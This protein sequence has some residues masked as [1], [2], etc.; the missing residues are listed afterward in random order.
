ME[1][2][3][4]IE[5]LLM[6]GQEV[7]PM[8]IIKLNGKTIQIGKSPLY[9]SE[10]RA[11]GSLTKHI[12]CNFCQGHYWHKGKNNTFAKEEGWNRNGGVVAKSELEFKKF[13]K[14]MTQQLLKDGIFTIEKI[15]L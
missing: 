3:G 14:E 8:Y 12:Y 10:G 6:G 9:S 11:K 2:E 4:P 5:H 1:Y 15:E 7:P 13:A